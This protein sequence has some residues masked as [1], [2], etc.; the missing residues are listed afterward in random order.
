MKCPKCDHNWSVKNT[1]E[2]SQVERKSLISIVQPLLVWYGGDY[3]VRARE[4][5]KC[6]ERGHTVE[7]PIEDMLAMMQYAR[8]NPMPEAESIEAWCDLQALLHC[9]KKKD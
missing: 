5:K 8:Q 6:A 1:A 2:N 4:C 3:R 9:Q 7:L